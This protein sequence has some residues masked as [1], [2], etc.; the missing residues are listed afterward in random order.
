MVAARRIKPGNCCFKGCNMFEGERKALIANWGMKVTIKNATNGKWMFDGCGQ[1]F[2]CVFSDSLWTER[3]LPI[4]PDQRVAVGAGMLA[5]IFAAL[6]VIN[7]HINAGYKCVCACCGCYTPSEKI[8][9]SSDIF[10]DQKTL[11]KSSFWMHLSDF[12]PE[13]FIPQQIAE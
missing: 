9:A 13:T 11:E 1:T 2:H 8:S 3:F 7:I 5:K 12:V 4:N 10:D 6:V